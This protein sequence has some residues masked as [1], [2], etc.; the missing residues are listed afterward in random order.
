MSSGNDVGMS[1]CDWACDSLFRVSDG[2]TGFFIRNLGHEPGVLA[3][4]KALMYR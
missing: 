2:E 3:Q 4:A 1:Y